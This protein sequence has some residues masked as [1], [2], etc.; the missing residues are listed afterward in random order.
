[1]AKEYTLI[2]GNGTVVSPLE[3][4]EDGDYVAGD[5]RA[6]NP[7]KVRTGG[8]GGG[9][10]AL[11]VHITGTFDPDLVSGTMDK[12]FAEIAA[13]DNTVF[14]LDDV[15]AKFYFNLASIWPP[16]GED[17][18]EIKLITFAFGDD[19]EKF[20]FVA[21]TVNDYPAFSDE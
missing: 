19:V 13:S 12:T 9:G 3:V 14:V 10:G 1:M 8:G 20:T 7:V 17:A 15:G 6:F 21:D 2:G 11:V 18:A 5:S 4:T 16:S